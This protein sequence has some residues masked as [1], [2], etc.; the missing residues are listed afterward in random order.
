M[1]STLLSEEL[2]EPPA[3]YSDASDDG[4][5]SLQGEEGK[6]EVLEE[7]HSELTELFVTCPPRSTATAV[8]ISATGSS[9]RI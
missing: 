8:F 4:G 3:S 1:R 9:F 5:N 6:E 7:R 2:A